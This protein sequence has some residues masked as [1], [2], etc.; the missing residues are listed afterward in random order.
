MPGAS[1]IFG[2]LHTVAY[3][4]EC[5]L[6]GFAIAWALAEL[7]VQGENKRWFRLSALTSLTLLLFI[8]IVMF[9]LLLVIPTAKAADRL[10]ARHP[11]P[12]VVTQLTTL[13]SLV[14]R[15]EHALVES[16]LEEADDLAHSAMGAAFELAN[17]GAAAPTLLTLTQQ[18]RIE[19]VRAEL[20]LMAP[21]MRDA[22]F[23]AR[24]RKPE[25]I[26]PA[27]Q[28]FRQAYARMKS[29]LAKPQ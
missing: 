9:T 23:A 11:E 18:T 7:R 21:S 5:W 16:N 14:D 25:L 13:D 3:H 8:V 20:D 15:L 27:M 4:T 6:V 10:N 26:E 1:A 29:E 28:E 19:A 24:R 2:V 22:W 12:V 17:T